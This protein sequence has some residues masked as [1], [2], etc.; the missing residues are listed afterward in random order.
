MSTIDEVAEG[1]AEDD[2]L[3]LAL[4]AWRMTKDEKLAQLPPE[5]EVPGDDDLVP[6]ITLYRDGQELGMVV[7][8]GGRDEALGVASL[9]VIGLGVDR[10][11][12]LFDSHMT[13]LPAD[14]VVTYEPGGL[15]RRCHEEG[16]CETGEVTD[17]LVGHEA[18]ADSVRLRM[19]PYRLF[20]AERRIAWDEASEAPAA[21]G[22]IVDVLQAAF[23]A[24][25][26]IEQVEA[27]AGPPPEEIRDAV[28]AR[29]RR[30]VV[31]RIAREHTFVASLEFG[32]TVTGGGMEFL[33]LNRVCHE[34]GQPPALTEYGTPSE[35]EMGRHGECPGEEG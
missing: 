10:L 9:A 27:V 16:A 24:P 32:Q 18:T 4:G 21:G 14:E 12:L 6:Q 30:E 13:K 19:L 1:I 25:S 5:A 34:C 2:D 31:M 23:K 8:H 3:A 17:V 26:L 35:V 29:L 22:Y 15:Q 20:P 7:V 33:P 28:A 11:L